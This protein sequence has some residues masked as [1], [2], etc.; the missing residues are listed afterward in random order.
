MSD[1]QTYGLQPTRLLC[2]WDSP[3]RILKWV[4]ISSSRGYSWPRDQTFISNV[5]CIGRQVLYHQRH[6]YIHTYSWFSLLYSRN[7]SGMVPQRA[8]WTLC[9]KKTQQ[10]DGHQW[11]KRQGLSRHW[12]C[13][14]LD[15][16]FPAPG[17]LRHKCLLCISCPVLVFWASSPKSLRQLDSVLCLSPFSWS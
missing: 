6:Q 10:G 4:V 2:P 3:A 8:P 13:Q 9:H 15:A 5:P 17:T 12:T 11:A 16:G 1:L 7:Q 14:C